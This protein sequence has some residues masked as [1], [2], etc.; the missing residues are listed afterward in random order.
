M[1]EA[2]LTGNMR[3]FGEVL[4]IGWESKKRTAGA[5][6]NA[7]L[8]EIYRIAMSSGAFS[9]KVSGA[10]GGGYMMFLVDPVRKPEVWRALQSVKGNVMRVQF[11]SQGSVAWRSR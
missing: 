6:T 2:L 7:A 10:G 1:K 11:T 4:N 8:E 9:G 3:T 5:V